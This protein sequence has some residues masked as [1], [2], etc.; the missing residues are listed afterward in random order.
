MRVT[1]RSRRIAALLSLSFAGLAL[2]PA[3]GS[4]LE[5]APAQV[6]QWGPVLNWGVQAKHA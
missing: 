1:R 4:A 6:G 3:A 2:F 5:G